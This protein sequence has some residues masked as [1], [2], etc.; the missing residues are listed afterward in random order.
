ML[1]AV[2]FALAVF[3]AT[4]VPAGLIKRLPDRMINLPR[5]ERWLALERRDAS[6]AFPRDWTR[7]LAVTI[8]GFFT[9]MIGLLVQA[10]LAV[11]PHL[12]VTWM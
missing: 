10:N 2:I 6:V 11:P 12:S 4:F 8:Y 5:K 9:A 3:A 1:M 7:W